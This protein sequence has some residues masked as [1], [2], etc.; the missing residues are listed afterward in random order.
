M[1]KDFN[2]IILAMHHLGLITD[3]QQSVMLWV[4]KDDKWRQN[5]RTRKVTFKQSGWIPK[6]RLPQSSGS[7]QHTSPTL[8][9]ASSGLGKPE[10]LTSSGTRHLQKM[11]PLEAG[12]I[13][14]AFTLAAMQ[15]HHTEADVGLFCHAW[16]CLSQQPYCI[17]SNAS[18]FGKLQG[19]HVLLTS[20][21]TKL[22]Q[23][24]QLAPPRVLK[25]DRRCHCCRMALQSA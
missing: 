25:R 6:K 23:T 16:S 15:E 10:P 24:R 21:L 19:S 7:C 20:S 11:H 8:L 1:V 3:W 12:A 17:S 13:L 2:H 9:T 4:W 5:F 14:I 18:Y 22:M